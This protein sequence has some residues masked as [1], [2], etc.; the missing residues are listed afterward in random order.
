MPRCTRGKLKNAFVSFG[1]HRNR[2]RFTFWQLSSHHLGETVR[3]F[4]DICVNAHDLE[5]GRLH[6][7]STLL[8]W[9]VDVCCVARTRISPAKQREVS[10]SSNP[11][12]GSVCT[13]ASE[14]ES[15]NIY[16]PG[17]LAEGELTWEAVKHYRVMSPDI[18]C[19]PTHRSTHVHTPP[20]AHAH[21]PF[22]NY[23]LSCTG[24]KNTW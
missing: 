20:R 16:C 14:R 24:S 3:T 18:Y 1:C 15:E 13:H 10:W 8:F 17:S 5:A 7:G 12:S 2:A 6:V 4:Q 19:C 22:L 23:P 9:S 11:F 21:T